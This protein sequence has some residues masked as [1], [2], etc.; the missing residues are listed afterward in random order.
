M[1]SYALHLETRN[2]LE[3]ADELSRH[4]HAIGNS[5]VTGNLRSLGTAL[6]TI[7]RLLGRSDAHAIETPLETI[8]TTRRAVEAIT[9]R[10]GDLPLYL[11]GRFDDLVAMGHR[12]VFALSNPYESV[13]AK[14]MLRELDLPLVIPQHTHSIIDFVASG[15]ALASTFVART[16]TARIAGSTLALA[17]AANAATADTQLS[18]A[19]SVPI[20][21]HQKLDLAWGFASV[22]APFALGYV[23]K[24]PFAAAC[25]IVAGA[26][27]L[28][29]ALFTDFRAERGL[30]RPRR[31]RGGP[32]AGRNRI[33]TTPMRVPEEAQRPLEGLSSAPSDWTSDS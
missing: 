18:L 25:Q 2:A 26:A 28:V 19:R 31:S 4:E 5:P 15:A 3:L 27:T 24:D 22:I 8:E 14:P 33:R 32:E 29:G 16:N 20:E 23:R 1:D 21:A 6:G 12:I 10:R 9:R 7:E 11:R 17:Q 13:P 30:T